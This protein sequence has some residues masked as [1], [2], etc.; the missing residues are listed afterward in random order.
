MT[1]GPPNA[2]DSGRAVCCAARR[3][4]ACCSSVDPWLP[5][6]LQY[7]GQSRPGRDVALHGLLLLAVVWMQSPYCEAET[8]GM[9]A[10]QQ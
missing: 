3:S 9:W 6:L 8:C 1:A 10:K 7:S 5:A 4:V 2:R